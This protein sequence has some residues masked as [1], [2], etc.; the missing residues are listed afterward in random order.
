[1]LRLLLLFPFFPQKCT[2]ALCSAE[3]GA[4]MEHK[5]LEKHKEHLKKKKWLKKIRIF[6]SFQIWTVIILKND[7]QAITVYHWLQ[8]K[9]LN[10][11]IYTFRL[12]LFNTAHEFHHVASSTAANTTSLRRWNAKGLDLRCSQSKSAFLLCFIVECIFFCRSRSRFIFSTL[13]QNQK[14]PQRTKKIVKYS[15]FE[16]WWT[17]KHPQIEKK[18]TTVPVLG[19]LASKAVKI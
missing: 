9:M 18:H 16:I 6:S 10:I 8:K 4:L 13:K 14:I 3:E 12:F 17:N 11:F 1:M 7:W 15:T 19:I 2:V 5:L